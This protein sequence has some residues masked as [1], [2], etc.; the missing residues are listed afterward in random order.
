MTKTKSTNWG[1]L[2]FEDLGDEIRCTFSKDGK[3]CDHKLQKHISNGVLHLRSR[4]GLSETSP[5]VAA[6]RARKI[7]G[8][9]LLEV[10]PRRF[11]REEHEALAN[12]EG[13]R[14]FRE[15]E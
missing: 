3:T 12:A 9:R 1:W 11:T 14:P 5:E 4:H 7:G 15:C 10:A 13:L 2:F 6:R 8:Q